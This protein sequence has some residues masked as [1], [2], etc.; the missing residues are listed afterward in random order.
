MK[1]LLM[2][3]SMYS[4][5][6]CRILSGRRRTGKRPCASFPWWV[7]WQGPYFSWYIFLW[8][9]QG[10]GLFLRELLLTA[11]PL[12]ATGGIH[13]DGF[14][15]TCDARASWG[16]REKKLQILKDTHAGPSRSP[17][18]DCTCFYTAAAA[19]S[20]QSEGRRPCPPDLSCPGP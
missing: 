12:L 5:L 16:D 9:K 2:A 15:D 13:M 6:R 1:A 3:F 19:R 8:K 17:E 14:L 11:V 10:Q 7:F 4:R 20:F 18:A